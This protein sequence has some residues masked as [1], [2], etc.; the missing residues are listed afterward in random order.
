MHSR[1]LNYDE[2]AELSQGVLFTGKKNYFSF[3][4]DGQKR[5]RV[6]PSDIK[7]LNNLE[8]LSPLFR[9]YLQSEQNAGTLQGSL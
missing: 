3:A 1:G 7:F 9:L 5:G 2:D 8:K 6:N 4:E